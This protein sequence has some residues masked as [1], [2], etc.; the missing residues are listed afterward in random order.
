MPPHDVDWAVIGS[1][2]GGSVCALRLAEKGH[3]V[4]VLEQG[5]RFTDAD[6]PRTAWDLRRF[7]WAPALGLRGIMRVR[8]FKHVSVLCGVGVGGG[9]LVYGNTMYVPRADA[10]YRHPQ[11]G[12]L[13]DWRAALAPHFETARCM[14]GIVEAPRNEASHRVMQGVADDLGEVEAVSPTPVAVLLEPR[15]EEVPDPYFGGAGPPRRGCIRCGECM[16]GCRFNAKNRLDKNYLWLAERLGVAIHADRRVVDVRPLGAPDGSDGYAIVTQRPGAWLRRGRRTLTARGVVVAAGTL[17]TNELLRSCKDRGSLPRLSDRLGELVRTNS[18]AITAATAADPLAHYGGGVA[19][20]TS[21][22]LPDGTH[23]TDNTYG[24]GGDALALTYGPLTLAGRRAPRPLQLL[25]G[26]LAH[27]RRTLQ[28]ARPRGWS[29]RS[30][31]FTAMQT[32]DNAL[33]LRR[34]RGRLDTEVDPDSTPPSAHLPIADEVAQ[35]AARRMGGWPQSAIAETL[36]GRPTSAHFLGGAVIGAD[37]SRGVVDARHRAFG[38]ESLLVCDGAA[39]PANIG[40]NPSLTIVALAEHAM[41]HVGAA[42]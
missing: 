22:F 23:V 24:V 8:P 25:L 35:L 40:V 31:V 19:I 1:G 6:L 4:A 29:R 38:Y 21:L 27:P 37:A 26:A 36:Q 15:G 18:E 30:I 13:A 20:S 32:T 11:W 3:R 10:F 33:R 7:V 2:F 39:V 14:F 5:R 16:L 28:R 12:E 42:D 17:G 41:A 34:R 9:S